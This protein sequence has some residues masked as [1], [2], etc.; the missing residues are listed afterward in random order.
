MALAGDLPLLCGLEVLH[1]T[2]GRS[3]VTLYDHVVNT[4]VG[5]PVQGDE[6]MKCVK[7]LSVS[8]NAKLF[9]TEN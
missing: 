5:C 2:T 9:R 7:R 1:P 4:D 6:H 3:L 8:G